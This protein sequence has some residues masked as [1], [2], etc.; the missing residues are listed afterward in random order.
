MFWYKNTS[1]IFVEKKHPFEN[2]FPYNTTI[3]C[4]IYK[5]AKQSKFFFICVGRENI[6]IKINNI[7]KRKIQILVISI[8]YFFRYQ[9]HSHRTY[10]KGRKW[11]VESRGMEWE[12][13]GHFE[14]VLRVVVILCI[15]L[16]NII[17]PLSTCL[18]L[19]IRGWTYCKWQ[20]LNKRSLTS[21]CFDFYNKL[22]NGF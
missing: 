12:A 2:N 13:K 14:F 1:E 3:M 5:N 11:S 21:D 6:Y 20:K 19:C 8:L 18:K 4:T 7:Q 17:L 15:P 9:F 22:P 16:A 10:D